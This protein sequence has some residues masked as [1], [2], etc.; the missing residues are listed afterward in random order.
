MYK[1]SVEVA[2]AHFM[3]CPFESQKIKKSKKNLE[4]ASLV[5]GY[6]NQQK[7]L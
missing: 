3:E 5:F 1:P 4:S 7:M 2:V 6:E